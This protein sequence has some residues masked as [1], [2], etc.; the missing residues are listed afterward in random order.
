M[1]TP[2][3]DHRTDHAPS[4]ASSVI[5]RATNRISAFLD[6]HFKLC[7]ALL[8]LVLCAWAIHVDLRQK[9][10]VDELYTLHMS[11]Q[12]TLADIVHAT[13]EGADGAPPLY[14]MLV[15]CIRPWISS[16]S[17]AVCLPSTLGFLGMIVCLLAFCRRRLAAIYAFIAALVLFNSAIFYLTEGRCYGLVLCC[18]TSALL[19]WQAAAEGRHRALAIPMLSLSLALMTALHYY[20]VFFLVPL[21]VAELVR[22][23]RSGR[24]D[25][26]IAATVVPVFLVLALHYPFIVTGMRFSKHYWATASWSNLAVLTVYPLMLAPVLFVTHAYL[27]ERPWADRRPNLTPPE[28]AMMASLFIMPLL[29]L[30]LSIYV[31]HSFVVRYTLWAMTGTAILSAALLSLGARGRS[32]AA[33]TVLG[34]LTAVSIVRAARVQRQG[35]LAGQPILNALQAMPS[36]EASS[37]EPILVA[38]HHAFVELSYYAPQA[39]EQRLIY[40]VDAELD[41]RYTN[42]DTSGLLMSAL[43]HRSNLR[44]VPLNAVLRDHAR[45]IL[46]ASASDY[47]PAHLATIGYRLRALGV[48]H[49]L[50]EVVAPSR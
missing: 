42:S 41:L 45:F 4:R 13:I 49:L 47:L 40:P 35:L 14:S 31:T 6:R 43:A 20:S 10:W 5:R 2:S 38:D 19:A 3:R 37:S 11:E 28:W 23:R 34:L 24:P 15:H 33:V 12:P 21:L 22:W 39:L 9:M 17:L 30:V 46:A 7:T 50:Y 25:W 32:V 18:A 36:T 1:T 8:I 27:T 48:S 29:I 26:A 16:D 44:I